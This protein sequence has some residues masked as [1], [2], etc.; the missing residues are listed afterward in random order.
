[1]PAHDIKVRLLRSQSDCLREVPES[2]IDIVSLPEV[3]L[4]AVL[5]CLPQSRAQADGGRQ[6]GNCLIDPARRCELECLIQQGCR[7]GD[8]RRVPSADDVEIGADDQ[9]EACQAGCTVKSP[10]PREK[11]ARYRQTAEEKR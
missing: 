10:N 9:A 7:I 11:P 3:Q 5:E 2:C 1:L 4:T 8:G 6:L